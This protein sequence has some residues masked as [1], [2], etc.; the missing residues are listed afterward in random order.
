MGVHR[1]PHRRPESD[2]R[3]VRAPRRNLLLQPWEETVRPLSR[4]N[5]AASVR[6][7]ATPRPAPGASGEHLLPKAPLLR[8]P[9][10]GGAACVAWP[11]DRA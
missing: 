7:Q 4:R 3:Q 8:A 10:P 6:L 5:G 9:R 11:Q 2:H 1:V